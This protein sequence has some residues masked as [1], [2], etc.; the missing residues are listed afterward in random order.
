MVVYFCCK[1]ISYKVRSQ[2]FAPRSLVLL[3]QHNLT[4]ADKKYNTILRVVTNLINKTVN[5]KQWHI[6]GK[7]EKE[8][9]ENAN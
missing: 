3:L 8:T 4:V 5:G 2:E 6:K 9:A 7:T 1:E